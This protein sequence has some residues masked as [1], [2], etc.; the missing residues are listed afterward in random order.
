VA[1][2]SGD[3]HDIGGLAGVNA[4][5]ID[6]CSASGS[7]L[8][9]DGA[10][11]LVG[12]NSG[13]ITNSRASTSV[14][15]GGAA[16][17]GLVGSNT[18]TIKDCYST[19]DVMGSG[20]VG[21]LV[22]GN[23][24][25]SSRPNPATIL[26]CYAIGSVS[27]N[28]DSGGLVGL[29]D[30][31]AVEASFWDV[32]TTG[33]S[34][35]SGGFGKTT[36]QM[37]TKSTFVNAG[38]DFDTP[39]WTIDPDADYPRLWWEPNEPPKYGGGTGEP[40]DPYLIHT[41]EQMNEIGANPEDWDKSF[42]L[43]ADIDLGSYAGTDFNLIGYYI[44]SNDNKPFAGVF[45][46]NGHTISNL[47]HAS[48]NTDIV[49][50]FAYASGLDLE[51]RDL[52]LIDPN[53]DAG[54]GSGVGSLVGV[55]EFGAVTGCYARNCNVSGREWIG[56]L[57]GYALLGEFTDCYVYATVLGFE[58]VGGLVGVNYAGVITNCHSVSTVDGSTKVGGLV[59]LNEFLMEFG[60]IFPGQIAESYAEGTVDGFLR[61]GGL[62]GENL[63]RIDNCYATADTAGSGRVGGLVGYNHLWSGATFMPPRISNCYASGSVS[64]LFR[65]GGLVGTDDGGMVTASF[66]D[67]QTSGQLSSA[68]GAGK[69]TA[70]MQRAA[71]FLNAGWD[72]VDETS[73]GIE[74]IWWIVERQDY[75]R[76]WWEASN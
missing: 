10:G 40:D 74:D 30:E 29:N 21:S 54:T 38:W 49:G 5:T 48:A 70:D 56:G 57:V 7:I 55:M 52:G 4:G 75:P 27:G 32:E 36:A 64:A 41:A 9:G 60:L 61:V 28:Y 51:I 62:V 12:S 63:A 17:G 20:C 42:K 67:M 16:V 39:I 72:F 23:Y 47:N 37:E 35:S 59:G 50:L 3:I 58:K 24:S 46:G 19:G 26:N 31:G 43:M 68:G 11:G 76:L 1:N 25:F 71:T 33:L 2:V 73:N 69:T 18:G 6:K 45:D 65:V 8:Q 34:A 44:S 22:G 15:A 66:W 14:L 53:V 13:T